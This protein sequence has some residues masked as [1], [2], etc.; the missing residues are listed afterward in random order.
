MQGGD[1]GYVVEALLP[2]GDRTVPVQV[3]EDEADVAETVQ[4]TV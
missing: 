4:K 3:G 2:G 1:F